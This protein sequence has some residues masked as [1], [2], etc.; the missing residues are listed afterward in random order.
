MGEKAIPL[1]Y[2]KVLFQNRNEPTNI[3]AAAIAKL[4]DLGYERLL[5]S[6]YFPD[7]VF[8]FWFSN[9]KVTRRNLSRLKMLSSPR[10]LFSRPLE[11][12]FFRPVKKVGA[13]LGQVYQVKRRSC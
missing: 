6:Q 8:F 11:N 2:E 5:H 13:S 10:S 4:V 12:V 7:L 3:F 9:Q 1:G